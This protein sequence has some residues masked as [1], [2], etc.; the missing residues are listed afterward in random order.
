MN[1]IVYKITNTINGKIYIGCHKTTDPDDDYM[2]SGKYLRRA[3]DK[4]GV[5]NFTKDVL[6]TFD[7]PDEMFLMESILVNEDFVGR[8]D[9]YNLKLGGEGGFDHL[10]D[11]SEAHLERVR[12]GR[13]V[14]NEN[15]A[16]E[17]A[18]ESI[19]VLNKDPEWSK[20]R[21]E[22]ARKTVMERY[23]DDSPSKTSFLGKTHT[24]ES[25]AKIGEANSKHQ[26]GEKNSQYGTCWIYHPESKKNKK[27][28][29]TLLDEY[30]QQG[31][32][33]GRKIK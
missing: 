31:W 12:K 17:K 21:V 24:E 25:K 13:R 8:S 6:Y 14:A 1:F 15:G 3:I 4:Y 29:K 9:T 20:Q 2:G 16:L 30:T 22:K 27:I 18:T 23:G 32:I 28:D 11:G 10:N 33:K 19:R 7:D 5:E 26:K